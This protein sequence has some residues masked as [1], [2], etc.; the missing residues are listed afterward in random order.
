AVK[1]RSITG[2]LGNISVQVVG[3]AFIV[4]FIIGESGIRF[5]EVGVGKSVN[6]IIRIT[7]SSDGRFIN[8]CGFGPVYFGNVAVKPCSGLFGIGIFYFKAEKLAIK[9]RRLIAFGEPPSDIVLVIDALQT[10]AY[11]FVGKLRKLVV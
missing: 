11:L 10:V 3:H 2:K 6:S 5:G 7:V 9:I 4:K 1:R 8:P